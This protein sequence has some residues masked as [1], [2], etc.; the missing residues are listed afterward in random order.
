MIRIR[1]NTSQATSIVVEKLKQLLSVDQ[2]LRAVASNQRARMAKRIHV[3]GLD[4]ND[5]AIGTYSKGYMKVRTGDFKNSTRFS[6]GK[7]KGEVK[8]FGYLTKGKN[9]GK[10]RENYNRSSDP[11]VISSLTRQM[12]N[13]LS[14]RPTPKGYGIGYN[15]PENAKKVGY[16]ENTYK[17]KIFGISGQERPL[18]KE[19]AVNYVNEILNT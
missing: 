14:I 16:V 3:D 11:K 19:D 4:C 15:N 1:S 2:M 18:M 9:K 7:K 6:H 10:A 13:D 8:D 5:S 12:E 17:K